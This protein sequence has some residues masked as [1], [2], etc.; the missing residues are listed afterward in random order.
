MTPGASFVTETPEI[1][2]DNKSITYVYDKPFGDWELNFTGATV[3]AHVAAMHA[4]AI[5]DPTEATD[6]LVKAIQDKD[7]E[8]LKP[9]AKW[10]NSGTEFT[11]LPDDPSLL[12]ADGPY[13]ITDFVENQYLT[14]ER[15][16]KYKGDHAGG[17]DTITVRYIDDPM[18]QVQALQNGEVDLIAPQASA[19]VLDGAR[20]RSTASPSTTRS[21]ARTSTSTSSSTTAVRS[22]RRPT[23]ATLRRPSRSA[24][25]SSTTIP[26]QDDRRQADRPAEPRGR[27][28]QL[29][30]RPCPGSPNYDDMVANNGSDAYPLDVDVDKA[31]QILADAGVTTPISVRCA[32]TGQPAPS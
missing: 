13:V 28:P 31:K 11:K 32:S 27:G 18:G 12:V 4:L 23:V 24:R 26:R 10:W 5:D 8:K 6:A 30:H 20:R 29:V 22:T 2:D 7:V 19:D 21:R 1:C 17:P 15:N 9:L 25:R 3:P 14:L 16:P